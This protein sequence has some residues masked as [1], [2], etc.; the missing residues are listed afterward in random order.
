[1]WVC[2]KH[3]R[4]LPTKPTMWHSEGTFLGGKVEGW[5]LWGGE[6]VED[7]IR[8]NIV[9]WVKCSAT[10]CGLEGRVLVHPKVNP[11]RN[12]LRCCYRFSRGVTILPMCE[13]SPLTVSCR[14]ITFKFTGW[15]IMALMLADPQPLMVWLNFAR[16]FCTLL[17]RNIRPLWKFLKI[18]QKANISVF[19]H[20]NY[21]MFSTCTKYL[22]SLLFIIFFYVLDTSDIM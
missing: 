13:F 16:A 4:N 22:S 14:I 3:P 21:L 5:V 7:E 9:Y 10:L 1:M 11:S 6:C 8:E 20:F 17:L 18:F 19:V 2:A 15:E 12:I